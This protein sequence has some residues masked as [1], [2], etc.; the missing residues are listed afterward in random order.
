MEKWSCA[1]WMAY[2]FNSNQNCD[3]RRNKEEKW[4]NNFLFEKIK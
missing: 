2:K 4:R 1:R 3:G